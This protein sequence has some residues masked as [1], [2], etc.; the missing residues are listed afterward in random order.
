ME[1]SFENIFSKITDLLCTWKVTTELLFNP[2]VQWCVLDTNNIN[3][4]SYTSPILGAL[5]KWFENSNDQ[6]ICT[7]KLCS[8]TL[9][10]LTGTYITQSHLSPTDNFMIL[11][12]SIAHSPAGIL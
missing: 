10:G 2:C 12:L 5:T 11:L 7:S 3:L 6:L 4:F 8:A 1:T 9:K